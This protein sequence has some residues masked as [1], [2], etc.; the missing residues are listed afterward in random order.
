MHRL[1]K[2]PEYIEAPLY[3]IEGIPA[4]IAGE[5]PGHKSNKFDRTRKCIKSNDMPDILHGCDFFNQNPRK[6]HFTF[7]PTKEFEFKPCIKVFK[8]AYY[9]S[10]DIDEEKE[11]W[12]AKG[13]DLAINLEPKKHYFNFKD[14]Y[15][16]NIIKK[17]QEQEK[18]IYV[19]DE[20]Q[21]LS[22]IGLM[23]DKEEFA[24]KIQEARSEDNI[25]EFNKMSL[26]LDKN[27]LL[28]HQLNELKSKPLKKNHDYLSKR[29]EMALQE[30][31]LKL[32]NMKKDIDYVKDLETWDRKFI[33]LPNTI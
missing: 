19:K 20:L 32:E 30:M 25:K 7:P 31:K 5:W 12:P 24:K 4:H 18:K 22:K 28:R 15:M 16:K 26:S 9:T 8:E 14:T 33:K 17:H 10:K 6:K 1:V 29:R 11:I 13:Q 21:Y 23:Q 2:D 3:K 27:S